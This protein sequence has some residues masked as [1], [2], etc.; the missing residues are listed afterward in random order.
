MRVA[1]VRE[2]RG[3]LASLLDGG[4]PV[5]VTRHGKMAGLYLP[6]DDPDHVPTDLRREL[7]DV[8][9]RH[10]ASLLEARGVDEEELQEDFDAHRRRRR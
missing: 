9:G 3:N 5:L 4:E 1:G 8:L 6:L 10:L 2:L 7:A